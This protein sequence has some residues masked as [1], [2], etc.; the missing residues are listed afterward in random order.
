MHESQAS[1]SDS[2]ETWQLQVMSS[3][4]GPLRLIM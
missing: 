2:V 4:C 3:L 1:L